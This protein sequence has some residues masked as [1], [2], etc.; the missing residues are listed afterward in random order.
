MEDGWLLSLPTICAICNRKFLLSVNLHRS[1]TKE[2]AA[3]VIKST[4]RTSQNKSGKEGLM[5][6]HLLR[7]REKAP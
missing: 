2:D 3:K 7:V 4:R 6:A 5:K 1:E